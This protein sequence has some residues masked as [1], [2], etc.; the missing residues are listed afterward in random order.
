MGRE[1]SLWRLPN[2]ICQS[3][4]EKK[5]RI[6]LAHRSSPHSLQSLRVGSSQRP[7]HCPPWPGSLVPL[8][9]ASKGMAVPHSPENV[10]TAVT[11]PHHF[12]PFPTFPPSQSGCWRSHRR[13][14][15]QL[16]TDCLPSAESLALWSAQAAWD[17]DITPT[18]GTSPED[19]VI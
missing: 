17:L 14:R 18:P 2:C 19:A 5:K 4:W 8:I 16:S 15:E 6:F 3:H 11:L 1:C 10:P 12:Q 9:R 7:Q 13:L